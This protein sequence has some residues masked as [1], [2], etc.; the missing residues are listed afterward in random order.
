MTDQINEY[1]D[2]TSALDLSEG[3]KICIL[4]DPVA[5]ILRIIRYGDKTHTLF[6]DIETGKDAVDTFTPNDFFEIKR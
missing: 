3:D 1:F 2:N 6:F 4:G 5:R